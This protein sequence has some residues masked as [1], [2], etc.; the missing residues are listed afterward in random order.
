MTNK[1]HSRYEELPKYL[2]LINQ[3]DY[4]KQYSRTKS[5][6]RV[7]KLCNYSSNIQSILKQLLSLNQIG[8]PYE[9]YYAEVFYDGIDIVKRIVFNLSKKD[10]HYVSKSMRHFTSLLDKV[11][12]R[13]DNIKL[14]KDWRRSQQTGTVCFDVYF[15]HIN[16]NKWRDV[17]VIKY[18]RYIS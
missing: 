6:T 11:P 3:L 9:R 17:I 7:I 12:E 18:P 10:Y 16:D 14:P 2:D 13:I 5:K 8:R 1:T 15:N 4:R